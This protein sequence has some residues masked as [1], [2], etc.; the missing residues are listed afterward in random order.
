MDIRRILF[1]VL[2]VYYFQMYLALVIIGFLHGLVFLPVSKLNF[3]VF[4]L[5]VAK[6]IYAPFTLHDS[7]FK[8]IWLL[9]ETRPCRSL[10]FGIAL[11]NKNDWLTIRK[12][13]CCHQIQC[14]TLHHISAFPYGLTRS[15]LNIFV[16]CFQV[17][18]SLFG[19]P[20]RHII[21]EKQQADEPS[22]SSNSS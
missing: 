6:T 8:V 1:N 13:K 5:S 20:S 16:L 10:N 17:I 14:C 7:H 11:W 3:S 19:P 4:W 12:E 2:Q 15:E 22:T 21:I 9:E 18:L